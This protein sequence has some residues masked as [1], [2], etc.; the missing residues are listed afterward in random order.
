MRLRQPAV[1]LLPGQV[2]PAVWGSLEQ[3]AGPD[4]VGRVVGGR[5]GVFAAVGLRLTVV[6][7]Q[8]GMRERDDAAGVAAKSGEPVVLAASQIFGGPGA[9]PVGSRPPA[10]WRSA[11]GSRFAARTRR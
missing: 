9:R 7:G 3:V 2:Y 10:V 8:H 1:W 6:V 4:Q 5:V 11:C